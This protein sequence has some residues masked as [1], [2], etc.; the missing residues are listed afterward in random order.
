MKKNR[1]SLGN[2]R[3]D[4]DVALLERVG[5]RNIAFDRNIIE[6]LWDD[7]EKLIYGAT[8]MFMIRAVK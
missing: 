4:W 3:P 5:Y 8:P 6:E 2:I 1:M 7:K